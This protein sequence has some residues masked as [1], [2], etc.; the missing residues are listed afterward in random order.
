MMEA[1]HSLGV[2]LVVVVDLWVVCVLW[3]VRFLILNPVWHV[4]NFQGLKQDFKLPAQLA[5]DACN[6]ALVWLL[7]PRR[8]QLVLWRVAAA[9]NVAWY[10]VA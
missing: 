4:G 1:H 6:M 7:C 8:Q 9:G 2:L 5:G 10:A 3:D